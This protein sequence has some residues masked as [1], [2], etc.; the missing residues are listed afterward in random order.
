MCVI[1][2]QSVTASKLIVAVSHEPTQSYEL[3]RLVVL[4][5]ASGRSSRTINFTNTKIWVQ[6]FEGR[7]ALD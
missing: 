6:M 4:M 7:L 5:P 1:N 3:I 2:Y